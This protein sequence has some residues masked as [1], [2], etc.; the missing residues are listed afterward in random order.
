[1]FR[2]PVAWKGIQRIQAEMKFKGP[3][4]QEKEEIFQKC[5][6]ARENSQDYFT[7]DGPNS[8][9][10]L[11]SRKKNFCWRFASILRISSLTFENIFSVEALYNI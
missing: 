8:K 9:A 7:C 1:M 5:R 10:P 2:Y 11:E 3:S 6:N 4:G